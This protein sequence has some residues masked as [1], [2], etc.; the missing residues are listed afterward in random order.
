MVKLVI[1]WRQV[2]GSNPDSLKIGVVIVLVNSLSNGYTLWLWFLFRGRPHGLGRFE[3]HQSHI[4]S[5]VMVLVAHRVGFPI[6]RTLSP[7]IYIVIVGY[8]VWWWQGWQ[9]APHH[10]S[11][12]V[13][14]WGGEG[15]NPLPTTF[16][17]FCYNLGWRCWWPATLLIYIFLNFITT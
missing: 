12:I 16:P 14:I 6:Y 13:T 10:F 2:G 1:G 8:Q 11:I 5:S 7:F 3:P 17:L 15:E 9:P 4:L